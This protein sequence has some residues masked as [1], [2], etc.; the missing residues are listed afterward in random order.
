MNSESGT[1]VQMFFCLQCVVNCGVFHGR[2]KSALF[3]TVKLYLRSFPENFVEVKK[4]LSGSSCI[5]ATHLKARNHDKTKF[6]FLTKQ[7]L[8]LF[9]SN[10]FL[11][12][13]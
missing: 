12:N 7:N 13:H 1:E 9:L 3:Q 5:A 11:E 2:I 8:L 4:S 6:E 10:T